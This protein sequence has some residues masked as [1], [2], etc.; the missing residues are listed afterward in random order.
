MKFEQQ[1]LHF[2]D[3]ADTLRSAEFRRT[4]DLSKWLKQFT[5]SRWIRHAASRIELSRWSALLPT[6]HRTS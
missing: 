5:S 4:D 1:D 3:I 6:H 2:E